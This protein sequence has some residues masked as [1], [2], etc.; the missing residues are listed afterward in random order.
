VPKVHALES[1]FHIAS[2][3]GR[4]VSVVLEVFSFEST[5][6]VT[7]KVSFDA[8]ASFTAIDHVDLGV[9][10]LDLINFNHFFLPS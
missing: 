9:G 4:N 7:I 3:N 10:K 2:I 5:F 6:E 8:V 1:F